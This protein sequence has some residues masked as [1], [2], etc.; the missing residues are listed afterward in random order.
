MASKF[1]NMGSLGHRTLTERVQRLEDVIEQGSSA[2]AGLGPKIRSTVDKW[3]RDQMQETGLDEAWAK[4][5]IRRQMHGE[6]LTTSPVQSAFHDVID[7]IK[8]S[9]E[10]VL[11][12][13]FKLED[14]G[15]RIMGA[16]PENGERASAVEINPDG[17]LD[18]AFL[19][20]NR[21][22]ESLARIEAAALRLE[23]V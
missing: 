3:V 15:N 10:R 7:R 20:L 8:G 19:A 17:T 9:T 5:A 18:H 1:P 16:L 2:A 23:R 22:D 6:D 21:L 13:A 14:I 12:S 4:D 11:R